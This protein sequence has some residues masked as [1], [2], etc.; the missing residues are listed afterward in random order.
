VNGEPP[1]ATEQPTSLQLTG[2][3]STGVDARV[4]A[5]LCYIAWW[6][7]GLIF[8]VIEQRHRGVRFHAA[9]SMVLFGGLSIVMALLSAMSVAMLLI[10]GEAFAVVRLLAE[11]V[12]LL[13]VIIWLVVMIK[14]FNGDSV[15]IPGAAGLAARLAGE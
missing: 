1:A 11:L 5:L 7:S 12:W 8:L 13:S 4:S 3:T 15:R 9:Q 10:S 6:L 14:T 2:E